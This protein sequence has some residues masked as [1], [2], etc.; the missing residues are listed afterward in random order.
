MPS[1]CFSGMQGIL[2]GGVFH[3]RQPCEAQSVS[4]V[5]NIH[6]FLDKFCLFKYFYTFKYHV[7]NAGGTDL[8]SV[9][10]AS[11]CPEGDSRWTTKYEILKF[12]FLVYLVCCFI[13][14]FFNS[15]IC[16]FDL[17]L[18][19]FLGVYRESTLGQCDASR[20]L[21]TADTAIILSNMHIL[22]D[23]LKAPVAPYRIRKN[24]W[25]RTKKELL[26]MERN[27]RGT[28]KTDSNQRRIVDVSPVP[29]VTSFVH[30]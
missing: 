26:V 4:Q 7:V 2:P 15:C 14:G 22:M 13:I 6:I 3:R 17:Y 28:D 16:S 10:L 9:M 21:C 5:L 27:G 23:G 24:G 11:H 30:V 20:S 8:L 19:V 25:K 1:L 12:L 18:S 29:S